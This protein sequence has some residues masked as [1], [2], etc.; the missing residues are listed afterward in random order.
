MTNLTETVIKRYSYTH[1]KV[2]ERD[3]M[4][5]THCKHLLKENSSKI[6]WHWPQYKEF[7]SIYNNITTTIIATSIATL[8]ILSFRCRVTAI[9]I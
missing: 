4:I 9:T 8:K 7:K 2:F 5:T 6:L 3:H 1:C